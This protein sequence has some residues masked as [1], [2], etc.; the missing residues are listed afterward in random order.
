M[1][2]TARALV[3]GAWYLVSSEAG[4]GLLLF[5]EDRDYQ[6]FLSCA[7]SLARQERDIELLEWCLLPEA[8]H[9]L[10]R[11]GSTSLG[12]YMRLLLGRYSRY[13]SD[14]RGTGRRLYGGERYRSR[15]LTDGSALPGV[16]AWMHSLPAASGL[17]LFADAWRWSSIRVS[18]F[19]GVSLFAEIAEEPDWGSFGGTGAKVRDREPAPER[20]LPAD[21]VAI[22]AREFGVHRS[23]L[24][25]PVGRAQKALRHRAFQECRTRWGM[26]FSEIARAFG[27][28]P[29]AVISALSPKPVRASRR[30]K[31]AG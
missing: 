3:E 25:N 28:T 16:A 1:P 21:P 19:S 10:V 23:R 8:L 20:M 30:R 31:P 5:R 26:N 14:V 15:M 4:P 29:A 17:V 22:I 12:R 7:E 9:L 27:V 13:R 11:D 6:A 2:R 24:V 18:A